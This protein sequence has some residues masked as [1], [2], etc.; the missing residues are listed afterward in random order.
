MQVMSCQMILATMMLSKRASNAL[1]LADARDHCCKS[2]ASPHPVPARQRYGVVLNDYPEMLLLRPQHLARMTP[3]A[4]P[5]S[6]YDDSTS[7]D[8]AR[9]LET[10]VPSGCIKRVVVDSSASRTHSE[11]VSLL[12]SLAPIVGEDITPT[13]TTLRQLSPEIIYSSGEDEDSFPWTVR[14]REIESVRSGRAYAGARDVSTPSTVGGTDRAPLLLLSS[15]TA[16]RST[17]PRSTRCREIRRSS[18]SM[19]YRPR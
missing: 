16:Y 10:P 6:L 1:N 14:S 11:H 9:M 17:P 4:S 7:Q 2:H 18:G 19:W 8:L 13:G 5:R 15:C 3:S 12:A